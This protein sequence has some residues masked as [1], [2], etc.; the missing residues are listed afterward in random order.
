MKEKLPKEIKSGSLQLGG[1]EIGVCVLDDGTR[2]ITQQGMT[3]FLEWLNSGSVDGRDIEKEINKLAE[4]IKLG[5][6][7]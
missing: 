1:Y 3:N 7:E 4:F 5:R 6:I 2:V